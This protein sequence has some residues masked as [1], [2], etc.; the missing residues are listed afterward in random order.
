MNDLNEY[1]FL[2][3][4][5]L[6]GD[7]Q[8]N[9]LRR[10]YV[11]LR[12]RGAEIRA[13]VGALPVRQYV[14]MLER[15]FRVSLARD[16]DGFDLILRPD[17]SNPRLGLRGA[18]S[19]ACHRDGRVY[20]NTTDN[21]V[22]V[23]DGA[24]R[25][26]LKHLAVGDEPSHL[27]LSHDCERLYVANSGTNDVTI[28][29][30]ARDE[31]IATAPTG[32]RPLLPCVAPDG[33]AVLLP[34]G[35]DQAVTVLDGIGNFKKLVP[36]GMAPHDIAVS[37][38]SRWAYQ[39]NTAAHTV[40]IIDGRDHSV[41]GEVKVGLGPG[42]IVFDAESRFAYVANTVSNDVSVIATATHEVVAMIP[43]DAGAHLPALSSD[44]RYGYVANFAADS[45]TVWNCQNHRAVAPIP[46]GIYPHFFAISPDGKT[47]VVSNTGESS[48][49][50][51]D[52]AHH[53]AKACLQVGGAPAHIAFSPDGELAFVG[54]ERDDEVAVID[55]RRDQ[56]L[57][58]VCAGA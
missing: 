4:S 49:C 48:V 37:P 22:A 53:K 20:A 13:R 6:N 54:C 23:I 47:I 51:I 36:V 32:K 17:G 44:G 7:E 40:T 29:D 43:A 12:G 33:K 35:P 57:D 55:L 27:E 24:S 15:G 28:V 2:D 45:L 34:S 46:V 19:V 14:S 8:V 38:D 11:T 25:Q 1:R 50:L 5:A 21:R 52:T 10:Q 16:S 9:E 31:A 42:H 56:L 30:T 3:L 58:R 26:L 39:P 18:H 41:R